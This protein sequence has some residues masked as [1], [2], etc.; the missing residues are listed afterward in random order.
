M[1]VGKYKE[2]A[3]ELAISGY[4]LRS[5]LQVSA[6][7]ICS[8]PGT[9]KGAHSLWGRQTQRNKFSAVWLVH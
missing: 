4:K 8:A 5:V 2:M 9:Q 1:Y 6:G 7:H 3:R